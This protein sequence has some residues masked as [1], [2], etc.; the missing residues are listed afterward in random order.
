[1]YK[2]C[3]C[4]SITDPSL[5]MRTSLSIPCELLRALAESTLEPTSSA[6]V[7]STD[8]TVSSGMALTGMLCPPPGRFRTRLGTVCLPG[9]THEGGGGGIE[10]ELCVSQRTS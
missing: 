8:T 7:L 2:R 4:V 10:S 3:E 5:L 1:M 6:R 9:H